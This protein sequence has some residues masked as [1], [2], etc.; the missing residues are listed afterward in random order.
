LLTI[1]FC[2]VPPDAVIDAA[3]P[4]FR[5]RVKL[6]TAFEP[7]PLLA[8]NVNEY[9][10]DAAIAV[11]DSVPVP[12]PLSTYIVP[13]GNVPAVLAIDGVGEP[14]VVTVNVP[15]T[16][17]VKLVL[18]LLVIA[19]AIPTVSDAEAADELSAMGVVT[20]PVPSR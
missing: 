9:G 18:L 7:T 19:G 13:F 16:P 6:C 20:A 11:P 5:V 10:P 1:A 2:G 8:V 12:L 17:T 14:V 3:A 15:K 4:T